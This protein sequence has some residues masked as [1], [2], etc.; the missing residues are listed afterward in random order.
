MS[1]PNQM[2]RMLEKIERE[3]NRKLAAVIIQITEEPK[4]IKVIEKLYEEP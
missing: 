1:G 3:K 2:E 4:I